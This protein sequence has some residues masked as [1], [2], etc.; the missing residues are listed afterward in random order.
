MDVFDQVLL[1]DHDVTLDDA[2]E[3]DKYHEVGVQNVAAKFAEE[4]DEAQPTVWDLAL[5][6]DLFLV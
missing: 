5:P 6:N 3:S 4:V 2:I 1:L